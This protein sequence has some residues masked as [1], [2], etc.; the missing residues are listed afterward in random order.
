M[1]EDQSLDR[2]ESSSKEPIQKKTSRRSN[3]LLFLGASLVAV[4]ILEIGLRLI[5][6]SLDSHEMY[7]LDDEIGNRLRPNFHG[8]GKGVEVAINSQGLRSPEVP[9]DKPS[10]TFR[11]LVLGD[12]WTFGVC[13]P[14]DETYP[15]HLQRILSERLPER[16]VEVINSGVSGYE[17]Y[18]ES[19][20]FKREGYKFQPDL[21]LIGYYPVNDIH[22]KKKKY[23]RHRK[24][25]S[26]HPLLYRIKRYP[27]T[28][29]L[30]YQYFQYV[31]SSLKDRL[32]EW[33]VGSPSFDAGPEELDA[34]YK[35]EWTS[36]YRDDFSGWQV[37]KQSL[38]DIA[39][40]SQEIGA[41]TALAVFPDLRDLKY[42]RLTLKARFLPV[43][44]QAAE[45]A[46]IPVI[47]TAP[48]FIDYE[49]KESEIVLWN[50]KG[51]THPNGKGYRLIAE[52]L[53]ERL[54]EEG[55]F[56]DNDL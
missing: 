4:F 30:T 27:K 12:S 34:H 51:S 28:D 40:L 53:A 26:D 2:E 38:I 42:Y 9:L 17:T 3:I 23:E 29:L 48:L 31:R 41:K 5:L 35:V 10:G 21:V 44:E 55:Y 39:D 19:V 7:V 45:T 49:G 8:I 24:E 54:I 6:P 22:D 43:L 18:N 46:K 13:V 11:I 36:L 32:I 16:S 1:G 33:W 37:A 25:R 50:R 47:D 20:Y 14:Q 15:A 56:T 52:F